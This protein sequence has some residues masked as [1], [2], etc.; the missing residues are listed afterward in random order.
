MKELWGEQFQSSRYYFLLFLT[1]GVPYMK[2]A[3]KPLLQ[4]NYKAL[5]LTCLAPGLHRLAETIRDCFPKV[6][7][8]FVASME[9]NLKALERHSTFRK[10]LKP[11]INVPTS[12]I[13][14]RWDFMMKR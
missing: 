9:K 12:P 1:Y 5:H 3:G 2:A 14:T 7:S 6:R 11:N 10:M 8:T 4:F 13:I